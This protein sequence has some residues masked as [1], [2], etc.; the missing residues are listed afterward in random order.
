M[1][2]FNKIPSHLRLRFFV[3]GIIMLSVLVT[4]PYG[5]NYLNKRNRNYWQN[6]KNFGAPITQNEALAIDKIKKA[7]FVSFKNTLS[8]EELEAFDELSRRG[9]ESVLKRGYVNYKDNF[10][11]TKLEKMVTKKMLAFKRKYKKGLTKEEK[12]DIRLALQKM[13][14]Q[15]KLVASEGAFVTF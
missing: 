4:V 11:I 12:R 15:E 9:S 13:S 6:G 10:A 7:I 2:K 1:F 5:L 3:S 14:L 8:N